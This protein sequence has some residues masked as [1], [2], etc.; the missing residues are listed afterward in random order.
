MLY[1]TFSLL[2]FNF[3][4]SYDSLCRFI[5]VVSFDN[6]RTSSLSAAAAAYSFI[7]NF[8]SVGN[9]FMNIKINKC[10]TTDPW[11][12]PEDIYYFRIV[13]TNFDFHGSTCEKIF[14]NI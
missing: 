3:K 2:N 8:I 7:S 6:D 12:T 11:G 1:F 13:V 5:Y 10:Q 9:S 4:I 14:H